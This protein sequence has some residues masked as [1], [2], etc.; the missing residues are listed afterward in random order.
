MSNPYAGINPFPGNWNSHFIPAQQF[1]ITTEPDIDPSTPVV[2]S[3]R[4]N[5]YFQVQG[6]RFLQPVGV[7]PRLN[8][9]TIHYDLLLPPY[10]KRNR[11]TALNYDYGIGVHYWTSG[12]LSITNVAGAVTLAPYEQNTPMG[13]VAPVQCPF[14]CTAV[15]A[16]NCGIV[17]WS[18]QWVSGVSIPESSAIHLTVQRM[19]NNVLGNDTYLWEWWFIG[20]TFF[21]RGH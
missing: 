20:L 15:N 2:W 17:P 14:L 5:S 9:A 21:W 19:R 12:D 18:V 16:G 6:I 13:S 11:D 1:M 8:P 7:S 3:N 4:W 10:L